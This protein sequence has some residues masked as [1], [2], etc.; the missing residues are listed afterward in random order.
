MNDFNEL[1]E[2][3]DILERGASKNIIDCFLFAEHDIIG[4]G[5]GE[6]D[7]NLSPEETERL[8]KLGVFYSDEYDSYVMFV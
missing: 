1:R 6:E 4:F 8:N 5:L 2:A 7:V 3:L